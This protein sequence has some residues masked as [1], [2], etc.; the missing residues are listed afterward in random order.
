MF[1]WWRSYSLEF[2]EF[3]VFLVFL[4]VYMIIL[5]GPAGTTLDR[6]QLNSEMQTNIQSGFTDVG[7]ASDWYKWMS[8]SLIPNLYGT[9]WYTSAPGTSHQSKI[10]F[11]AD[12][13]NRRIGTVRIRLVR[14]QD[15]A[16]QLPSAYRSD[17]Q[18]LYP[19]LQYE[20]NID[21]SPYSVSHNFTLHWESGAQLGNGGGISCSTTGIQYPPS[22]YVIDLPKQ[23]T[24]ATEVMA[25][26]ERFGLIDLATRAVIVD[27][28]IYNANTVRNP[29]IQPHLT[30]IIL[31]PC[32]TS[33]SVHPS[34]AT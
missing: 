26:L 2:R 13:V 5:F 27:Y 31:I 8:S 9:E 21:R 15:D 1:V 30:L 14:V 23:Y 18:H 29:T 16:Q 17:V 25:V 22:G 4:L 12:G 3:L 10:Q 6:Y 24:N 33:G 34:L 19:N 11:A 7:S 28:S 20:S 32:P